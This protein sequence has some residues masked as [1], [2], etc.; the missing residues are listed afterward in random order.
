MTIF[1]LPEGYEIYPPS[2]P[3]G[4][5]QTAPGVLSTVPDETLYGGADVSRM[6]DAV[7]TTFIACCARGPDKDFRFRV[8]AFALSG[9]VTDLALQHRATG[10]GEVALDEFDRQLHWI[11]WEGSEFFT[12][13]VPGAV[14]FSPKGGYRTLPGGY[15][16]VWQGPIADAAPHV[17]F[18]ELGQAVA[19]N[20]RLTISAPAAGARARVAQV[21]QPAAALTAATQVAGVRTYQQG[22][23]GGGDSLTIWADNGPLGECF[24][25]I[26]GV[27]G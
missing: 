1:Q 19:Y 8:F 14:A 13:V 23:V 21:M 18:P 11:A 27:V 22:L 26:L 16:R 17:V 15:K 5:A 12:D 7:G 3:R 2:L 9:A 6:R 24:V 10:R 25:D 4:I 20:V